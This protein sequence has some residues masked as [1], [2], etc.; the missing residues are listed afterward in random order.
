[1]VGRSASI[2]VAAAVALASHARAAPAAG[3]V[4]VL[5]V[6]AGEGVS[7]KTARTLEETWLTSL[8]ASGVAVLGAPDVARL[9]GFEKQKQMVG[10]TDPSCAAEIAGS[11]GAVFLV[12]ADVG[13]VGRRFVVNAKVIEPRGAGVAVRGIR[14]CDRPDDLAAAVADLAHEIAAGLLATGRVSRAATR[15]TESSPESGDRQRSRRSVTGAP[16]GLPPASEGRADG[17]G[18]APAELAVRAG[19]GPLCGVLGVGLE[20]RRGWLGIAAGTGT[21]LLSG[22]AIAA[23]P[24]GGPYV[25]IHVVLARTGPLLMLAPGRTVPPGVGFGATAGWDFRPVPQLSLRV[26]AGPSWNSATAPGGPL[27]WFTFDGSVGPVF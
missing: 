12:A 24:G 17:E 11:M 3:S 21:N 18:R 2:V 15:E 8:H 16:A 13:T 26:G 22:G 10:C 27:R 7:E 25:A 19:F 5:G 1:V 9:L 6:T 4:F 20:Y 14:T 23:R